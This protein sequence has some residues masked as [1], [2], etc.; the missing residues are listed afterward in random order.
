[1]EAPFL[2]STSRNY[3]QFITSRIPTQ[4]TEHPAPQKIDLKFIETDSRPSYNKIWQIFV[5]LTRLI[6]KIWPF[7][8]SH[9]LLEMSHYLYEDLLLANSSKRLQGGRTSDI[10]YYLI[11]FLNKENEIPKQLIKELQQ[12]AA[13]SL[14]IEK[15]NSLPKSRLSVLNHLASTI[16]KA[17]RSLKLNESCLIPGGI[18]DPSTNKFA[19]YRITHDERKGYCFQI[20]SRDPTVQATE[21]LAVNGQEKIKIGTTFSGLALADLTDHSW[22]QTLLSLQLGN[23]IEEPDGIAPRAAS[24]YSLLKPFENHVERKQSVD[25]TLYHKKREGLSRIQT[26]WSY[27]HD[28]ELVKNRSKATSSRRKLKFNIGVLFR[29]FNAV[30]NTLPASFIAREY[31]RE[32]IRKISQKALVLYRDGTISQEEIEEIHAKLK[33]IKDNL[34]EPAI[35][36][37]LLSNKMIA[38]PSFPMAS[39]SNV[40]QPHS[41]EPV[42]T[43]VEAATTSQRTRVAEYKFE[44]DKLYKPE[45][46]LLSFDPGNPLKSLRQISRLCQTPPLSDDALKLQYALIPII[47]TFSLPEKTEESSIW[48]T[49]SE[50][51]RIEA[52]EQLKNL[53]LLLVKA[54]QTTRTVLP[55]RILAF[56]KITSICEHLANLNKSITGYDDQFSLDEFISVFYTLIANEENSSTFNVGII[57][58]MYRRN[59]TQECKV[60]QEILNYVNGFLERSRRRVKNSRLSFIAALNSSQNPLPPS[61]Q[62]D[63]LVELETAMINFLDYKSHW[64]TKNKINAWGRPIQTPILKAAVYSTSVEMGLDGINDDYFRGTQEAIVDNP[65]RVLSKAWKK[66]KEKSTYSFQKKEIAPPPPIPEHFNMEELKEI[67]LTMQP[68][69][70]IWSLFGLMQ[71]RPHLL[72]EP[73]LCSMMELLVLNRT[74][75]LKA[76]KHDPELLKFMGEFLEKQVLFYQKQNLIEPAL[77]LIHLSHSFGSLLFPGRT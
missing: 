29:Y 11:D 4:T 42:E 43:T 62:S 74:N 2:I 76:L 10:L 47:F 60:I 34:G 38:K 45:P 20:L 67:L 31:L 48:K 72:Q 50:T 63:H 33:T 39:P 71:S 65:Q 58:S 21:T 51:D 52:G 6:S 7:G 59:D 25:F 17:I 14:E 8:A 57:R 75:I 18:F 49:L 46:E 61:K 16:S 55:D 15:I 32:G 37:P 36:P 27:V 26:L 69:I 22:L 56:L 53:A 13:W 9:P 19:F 3:Y 24:L 44:S 35:S 70:A 73:D 30:K 28:N 77:F 40:P 66:W 1:M 41:I 64:K 54:T 12:A 23:S 68:S 5:Y